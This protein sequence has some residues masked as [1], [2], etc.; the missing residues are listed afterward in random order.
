MHSPEEIVKHFFTEKDTLENYMKRKVKVIFHCEFSMKRGPQM[1]G[2]LRE[3]DRNFNCDSYPLLC[4]P[5]LYLLEG[6]YKNFFENFSVSPNN[7]RIFANREI[8]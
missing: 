4:F 6:G 2:K 8:T 7:A 3:I 1:T 5:E